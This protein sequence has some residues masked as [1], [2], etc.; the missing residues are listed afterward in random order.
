MTKSVIFN[1]VNSN[2][3]Q[4]TDNVYQNIKELDK[5]MTVLQNERYSLHEEYVKMLFDDC[6]KNIKRCFKDDVFVGTRELFVTNYYMIIKTKNITYQMR[7]GH[8]F[9]EHNYYV[10]TFKYPYDNSLSPFKN[11]LVNINYELR[12]GRILEID[13]KE[14]LDK[15]NQVNSQWTC[16]LKET[17]N[18]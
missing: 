2:K 14:F 9:D 3:S 15:F 5:K 18:S 17:F 10:L 11:E 7:Q 4:N 1:K 8:D 13:S 12:T 16:N 6:Q